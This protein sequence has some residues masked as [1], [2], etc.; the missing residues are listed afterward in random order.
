MK[1]FKE[2][3]LEKETEATPRRAYH[4]TWRPFDH[5]DFSRLGETTHPNVSGTSVEGYAMRLAKLGAWASDKP[6]AKAMGAPVSMPVD[7]GGRGKGFKT[8]NHL[9]SAVRKAGGPEALRQKLLSKG[10]GHVHV[11]DEEFGGKSFVAL[12]PDHFSVVKEK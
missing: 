6:V 10:F 9:E 1:S 11:G 12:S 4:A 7:I 5:F 3:L 8:L 2:F